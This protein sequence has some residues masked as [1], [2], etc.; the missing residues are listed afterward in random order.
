MEFFV[1]GL[2]RAR[3]IFQLGGN[4]TIGKGLVRIHVMPLPSTQEA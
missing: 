2:E 1:G 3:H 4:A